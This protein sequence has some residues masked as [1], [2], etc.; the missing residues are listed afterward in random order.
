MGKPLY[1][2]DVYDVIKGKYI[3]NGATL[4]EVSDATGCPVGRISWYCKY[5]YVYHE[6]YRFTKVSINK[7]GIKEDINLEKDD[8][9]DGKS[10]MTQMPDTFLKEWEKEC[11]RVK[12][13]L[14]KRRRNT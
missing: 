2:W 7:E 9:T 4:E 8:L 12:N 10:R 11:L 5:N 6:K 1:K 3:L 13:W 14:R